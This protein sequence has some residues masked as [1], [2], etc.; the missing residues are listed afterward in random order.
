M[1][2]DHAPRAR[3]CQRGRRDGRCGMLVERLGPDAL[4]IELVA[5]STTQAMNALLEGDVA[6]VGVIGIG[7]APDVKRARAAHQGRRADA[8]AGPE[9]AH[10]ARLHR[11]HRRPRRGRGRRCDRRP[12]PGR[13][14]GARR[15]RRVLRRHAG[16]RGA[17]R[18]ARPRPRIATC[19]GHELTGTYG[20]ETRT[21]T[22]AV[23][24]SILPLVQR[25]AA[26]VEQAGRSMPGSTP[27]CSCCA[28]TAGR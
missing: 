12:R 9:A 3:W 24:A 1:A 6:P 14:Q 8:G 15:Q 19:A 27:R 28:E 25:T 4:S 16:A 17:G 20:L 5:F 18:P 7:A 10:R 11:R 2:P 26:I 21:V 22:A 13:L 23:N